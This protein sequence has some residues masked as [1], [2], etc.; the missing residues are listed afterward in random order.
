MIESL[1]QKK[2]SGCGVCV[3]ICPMDVFRMKTEVDMVSLT[4]RGLPSRKT[5]AYLAY[6]KDCMTCFTCELKCP[7]GA[8]RV[9][10]APPEPPAIIPTAGEVKR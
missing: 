10:F 1:D 7:S 6:P 5:R 3:E 2:C 8:I 9:A 4:S